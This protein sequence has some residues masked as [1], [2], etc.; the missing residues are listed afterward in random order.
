MS[1]MGF[2]FLPEVELSSFKQKL[3]SGK[4]KRGVD[5]A[6]VAS[7]FYTWPF[8]ILPDLVSVVHLD[9]EYQWLTTLILL[10]PPPP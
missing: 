8:K 5:C 1:V 9:F 4:L 7:W 10:P 2:T 3:F 6:W